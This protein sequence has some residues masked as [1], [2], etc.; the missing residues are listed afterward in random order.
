MLV[1]RRNVFETNSSSTHSITMCSEDEYNKWQKGG[2]LYKRWAGE[3]YTKEQIIEEAKKKQ[4]KYLEEQ[5]EGKTIH[6]YQEKYINARTDEELY[7]A[8]YDEEE[9][10]NYD[11]F[12]DYIED[13]YE[14][15][16]DSYTTKNGEK[17]ISFGYFGY[18]G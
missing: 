12:W 6:R 10:Q 15:F 4:V 5:Q 8:E 7:K 17:I 3:F 11:D 18:N 1:V 16:Q 13:E 14:T 9:Y 2:L